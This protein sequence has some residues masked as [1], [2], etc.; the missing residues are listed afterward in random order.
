[1][2]AVGTLPL[3]QKWKDRLGLSDR[4]APEFYET[5]DA[6]VDAPHAL[7][8]RTAFEDLQVTAVFCVQGVPTVVFLAIEQYEQQRV[9]DLHAALWNQ[10][11]A[12][13]LLVLCG[14]TLRAYSLAKKPYKDR[15]EEFDNRCLVT[16]LDNTTEVLKFRNLIDGAESGR[17]W[18]EHTDYFNPNERIDHVLLEN[19]TDSHEKLCKA[20][21]SPDAAQALLIQAMFIDRKSVV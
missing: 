15:N 9:I 19:L 14:D 21:L 13:L 16:L 4:R 12:S 10:G 6:V 7:A 5:A 18:T 1:M 20:N 2:T 17:L 3:E 11:L 8:L